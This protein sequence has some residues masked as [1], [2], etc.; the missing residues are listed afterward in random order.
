V[1]N[2]AV[3]G[4]DPAEE[5]IPETRGA[6]AELYFLMPKSDL[7][8]FATVDQSSANLIVRTGAVGSAALRELAA[9]IDAVLEG[10]VPAGLTAHITGNAI[11][12]TRAADGVA[13]SQPRTV[14]LAAATIFVLLA[15]GLRSLRLGLV[16][17]VPNVVPV[18]LFFGT[19]GGGVAALSLPTSLIGSIA[20]G[21]AIDAT[22]HY[23]VRY[24]AER[25]SGRTPEEAVFS[26]NRLVGRPI[27][28][29]S[30][31]LILGFLA[32]TASQFATLREFGILTALTMAVCMAT[33]LL[34]LPAILVRWRL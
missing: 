4:D 24:R 26:C 21:I 28:I 11:L 18:L 30:A 1:L 20:L 23:L 14:G 6:V 15:V 2:R 19:L 7:Q 33:D 12:L 9:E 25:A 10:R 34:L 29:A 22:A 17:M 32:V 5:R 16:A 31:V 13:E 3:A 8:R 27:V